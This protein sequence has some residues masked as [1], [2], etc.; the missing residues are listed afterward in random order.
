MAWESPNIEAGKKK[1]VPHMICTISLVENQNRPHDWPRSVTSH[2]VFSVCLL[3]SASYAS[4]RIA[5]PPL[6]PLFRFLF[7]PVSFSA[8]ECPPQKL[9]LA[10]ALAGVLDLENE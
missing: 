5:T 7:V 9:A 3:S 10:V 1:N 6:R 2:L 4:D 8:E